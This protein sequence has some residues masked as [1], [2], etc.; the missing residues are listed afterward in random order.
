MSRDGSG[1]M[2]YSAGLYGIP[3]TTIES[4]D[5]NA[6]LDD[7]AQA[8]SDS[9]NKDGSKAFSANQSMGSNRITNLADGTARTN[10]ANLGQVQDGLVNW[11]DSGGTAD[12][13]TATY[14]PAVTSVSD[15]Q[16]FF[17]RASAANATTTPTFKPNG[18]T[19]RNITKH[20]DQALVAGDIYGDGHELILRYRSSDTSYELLNPIFGPSTIPFDVTIT[21]T[22]AGA[23]I[24]P[25]LN[26]YRNSASPADGDVIGAI[27]FDGEDSGG[28]QTTY[29]RIVAEATD[30]TDA[31]EDGTLRFRTM[32]AGSFSDALNVSA[33]VFSPAQTDKGRNTANFT[34][35]YVGGVLMYR[36]VIKSADE[37]V[38]NSTSL[39]ADD[40]LLFPIAANEYVWSYWDFIYDTLAAADFKFELDST[41]ATDPTTSS[42]F[43]E[44]LKPGG[45]AY[46]AVRHTALNQTVSLTSVSGGTGH[47]RITARFRN[48]ADAG[49][50]RLRFAQDTAN[51][52]DTSVLRG[53]SVRYRTV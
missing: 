35:Y 10:A 43:V 32:T 27:D 12:A 7:T 9:I 25:E 4:A 46:E 38:N 6:V 30:V 48:G 22:D 26:L 47:C 40:E 14:S 20:G 3:N 21:S 41:A 18:L 19:A 51:A 8:L 37:A 33:G 44:T 1:N 50:I 42:V 2:S 5:F 34:D 39:Q 28:T 15:G 13:I 16:L 45:T 29:A 36:E 24:G 17:V 49:N 23:S 52:S 53:S 31:T 11:I